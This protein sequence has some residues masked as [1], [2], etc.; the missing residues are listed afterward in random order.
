MWVKRLRG[1]HRLFDP[2]HLFHCQDVHHLVGVTSATQQFC[3]DAHRVVDVIEE[4]LVSGTQV[5][6]PRLAIRGVDK[7][8][9]RAFPV[10]GE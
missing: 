6:Q 3:H 2:L 5:V 1:R 9:A 10:A 4:Q 8:I 7:A